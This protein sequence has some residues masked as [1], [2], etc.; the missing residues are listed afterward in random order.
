[1]PASPV[2]E[3]LRQRINCIEEVQRRFSQT[4]SIVNE[5]D[6]WLP[7][8][9][10]P[11]GCIHEVKGAS[12]AGALAFSA[13]LSARNAREEGNLLYIAPDRSHDPLG[14]LPYGVNLDR[15][16]YVFAK[17]PQNLIEAVLEALRCPQVSSVMALVDHLDLTGSRKLQLAAEASGATGFLIGNAKNTSIAAPI[18]RWKISPARGRAGQSLAEPVWMLELLYSRGGRPGQWTV[19][20]NG[21][22][23]HT[24]L[25]RPAQHARQAERE[26]LAG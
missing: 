1:M 18:T 6:R 8:G 24:M 12:L 10:L 21:K 14:L 23:L 11:T 3:T 22:E 13:L 19:E 9:G 16:I 17:R 26:A 25:S 2:I 7:F 20:W 5:I 15:I 4:I